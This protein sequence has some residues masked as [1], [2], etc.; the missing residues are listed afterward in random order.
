M[1]NPEKEI[2]EAI[3]G[4]AGLGPPGLGLRFD[5]VV[6][7]VLGRLRAFADSAAPEG[8]TVLVTSSAPIRV[9]GRTA[10]ALRER[11]EGLLA[12]S[13]AS[14]AWSDTVYDNR[15]SLRLVRHGLIQRPKLIGFVH[16]PDVPPERL[17]GPAEQWL[18]AERP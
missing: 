3:L 1:D 7:R 11:I 2:A 9:P 5:R 13:S 12:L 14:E 8:L 17:L 10:E 18:R 16:N 6:V 15:V 4:A